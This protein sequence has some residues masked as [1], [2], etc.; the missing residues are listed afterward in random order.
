MGEAPVE[1]VVW[2]LVT[3]GVLSG[4]YLFYLFI[5]SSQ[6]V[7]YLFFF[8]VKDNARAPSQRGGDLLLPDRRRVRLGSELGDELAHPL[9]GCRVHGLR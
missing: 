4:T 6:N 8:P 1:N 2:Y 9:R 3:V 7:F 5:L